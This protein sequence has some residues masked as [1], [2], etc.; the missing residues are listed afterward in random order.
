MK[1]FSKPAAPARINAGSFSR[2]DDFEACRFRAKLKY[3]DRIPEP[4][5]GPPPPGKTEWP[6][7]RGTR[8]H[9]EVEHFVTGQSKK[10]TPDLKNFAPELDKVRALYKKRQVEAEAMWCFTQDWEPTHDRDFANIRFR[11]KTDLTVFVEDQT[12]AIVIDW[13]TGKRFGNEVKHAQQLQL[14]AL[15]VA[16]KFPNVQHITAEL[17]YGDLNELHDMSATRDQALRFFKNWNDRNTRMMEADKF[18]PNPNRENCRYCPFAH[19]GTGHCDKG[20]R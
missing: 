3:I 11:I 5:R 6:N 7:D 8:I 1:G 4:D 18:P 19:W 9:T 12:Q 10:L 17:W 14:Y 16:L 15:G 13:K 20:V 2:L